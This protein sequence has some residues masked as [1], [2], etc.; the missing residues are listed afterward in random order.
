MWS[1]RDP[2]T[3]LGAVGQLQSPFVSDN[4]EIGNH[5]PRRKLLANSYNLDGLDLHPL[6]ISKIAE[7]IHIT[8]SKGC[9]CYQCQG[10]YLT[11]RLTRAKKFS[12]KNIFSISFLQLWR[13]ERTH[14]QYASWF[15]G[16]RSLFQC[17]AGL[18]TMFSHLD[19]IMFITV[20]FKRLLGRE[21]L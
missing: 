10:S 17:N 18:Q 1:L 19:T 9:S 16:A 6:D 5:H 4:Q 3:Q 14:L 11:P 20:G 21:N 12:K 15:F 2:N 8:T 13:K 7:N